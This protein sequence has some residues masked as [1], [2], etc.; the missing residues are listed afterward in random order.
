MYLSNLPIVTSGR[1][2]DTDDESVE[3]KL[4]ETWIG[5]PVDALQLRSFSLSNFNIVGPFGCGL[6]PKLVRETHNVQLL[7]F[8]GGKNV[9]SVD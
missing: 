7:L 2:S 4:P 1:R 8:E 5:P 3:V 6:R 9:K